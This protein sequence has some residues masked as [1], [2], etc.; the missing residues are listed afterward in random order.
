LDEL[1]AATSR[2]RRKAAISFAIAA[3]AAIFSALDLHGWHIYLGL[4]LTANC[5]DLWFDA[6]EAKIS[7]TRV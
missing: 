2:S 3:A 4:G 6:L 1:P 7:A 5:R